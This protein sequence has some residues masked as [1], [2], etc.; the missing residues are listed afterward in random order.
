MGQKRPSS[1]PT[2]LTDRI[3]QA[4]V[5]LLAEAGAYCPETNRVMQFTRD[6]PARLLAGA[7]ATTFGEGRERKTMHGRRPDTTDD[8]PWVHVGGGIYTTDEQ[9]YMDT[10]EKMARSTSSTR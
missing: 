9:V 8:R 6:D 1:T 4:A 2:N 5:D 7:K 10:V 3:F